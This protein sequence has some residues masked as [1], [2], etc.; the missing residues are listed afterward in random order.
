[1]LMPKVIEV[2]AHPAPTTRDDFIDGLRGAQD[3]QPAQLGT[4]AGSPA[5]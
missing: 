5:K 4:R 3:R 2:D 1:M